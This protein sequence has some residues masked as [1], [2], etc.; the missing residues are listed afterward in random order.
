MSSTDAEESNGCA[1]H[2]SPSWLDDET[3]SPRR[4]HRVDPDETA[5][6]PIGSSPGAAA[7]VSGAFSFGRDRRGELTKRAAA[8]NLGSG[9]T[10]V[11]A[12]GQRSFKTLMGNG[13]SWLRL[14]RNSVTCSSWVTVADE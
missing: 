4:L 11:P 13:G 2:G 5:A 10:G 6:V 1:S 7:S 14:R 3:R 9:A 12:A 8:E